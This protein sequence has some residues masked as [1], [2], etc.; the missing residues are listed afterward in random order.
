MSRSVCGLF[1]VVLVTVLCGP[2]FGQEPLDQNQICA[3]GEVG[4]DAGKSEATLAA[5]INGERNPIKRN[6]LA[7]QLNTLR[8]QNRMKIISAVGAKYSAGPYA[9]AV[10]LGSHEFSNFTGH[11]TD[12][13]AVVSFYKIL[14]R[15]DCSYPMTVYA[16]AQ[17]I[18]GVSIQYAS[19]LRV[20]GNSLSRINKGDKVVFGGSLVFMQDSP[21]IRN[22]EISVTAKLTSISKQ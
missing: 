17:N 15:L 10:V 11:L 12:F 8:L 22:G 4:R 2:S 16:A 19:D 21:S 3:A 9:V 6:E 13:E 14:I 20:I 1:A 7:Q 18:N 5:E